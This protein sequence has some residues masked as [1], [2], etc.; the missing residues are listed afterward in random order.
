VKDTGWNRNANVRKEL[1]LEVDRRQKNTI[2]NY[3]TPGGKYI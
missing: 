1:T 3:S 2:Q